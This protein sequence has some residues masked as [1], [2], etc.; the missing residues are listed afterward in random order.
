MYAVILAAGKGTRMSDLTKETPKPLIN[1]QNRPIVSYTIDNLPDEI[2][3]IIFVVG[4]LKEQFQNTFGNTHNGMNIHY[5]VQENI[6]GTDGALRMAKTLLQG[7]ERFMVVMGD[8]L[9]MSQDLKKLIKYPYALL[10]D[11]SFDAKNFGLISIDDSDNFDGI[12]EKS[13]K[14]SEGLVSTAAYVLGQEY[15]D[16]EPVAISDTEF[17]LP[18]TLLGLYKTH[19]VR[20]VHA[21]GWQPVGNPEQLKTANERISEFI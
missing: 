18:Q 6:N 3:D 13:D 7:E 10:V 2:T 9:Y 19:P 17:G 21:L 11:Y 12:I 16:A 1:I 8:D 15:F 5:V 20:V 4:Y 14:H